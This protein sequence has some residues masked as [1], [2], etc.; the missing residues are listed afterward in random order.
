LFGDLALSRRIDGSSIRRGVQ[1]REV[2]ANGPAW[3][4]GIRAR[5]TVLSVNGVEV[6]D[7][8]AF[9]LMIAQSEPGRR[10]EL[11]VQRSAEIFETYATLIQEPPLR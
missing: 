3:K 4:A 5:D 8:R 7:A 9:L 2:T 1:V 10:I 11:R 6:V